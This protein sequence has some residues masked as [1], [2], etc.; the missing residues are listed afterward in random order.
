MKSRYA[1]FLSVLG[2]VVSSLS[3]GASDLVNMV[4]QQIQ[5]DIPNGR[6]VSVDLSKASTLSSEDAFDVTLSSPRG[7]TV[8]IKD[9]K[10]K[11]LKTALV[12]G[13]KGFYEG[14]PAPLRYDENVYGVKFHLSA[15]EPLGS[16]ALGCIVK[17]V[18]EL[19]VYTICSEKIYKP[20][21]SR[22]RD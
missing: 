6:V 14:G 8:V 15:S 16:K 11:L 4:C 19:D 10:V 12:D 21:P 17:N 20:Q 5:L 3:F 2:L 1:V 13:Q 22:R 18:D 9:F 7:K